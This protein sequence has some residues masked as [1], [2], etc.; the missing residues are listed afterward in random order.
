M[1]I[2]TRI[3]Q[4][5]EVC[6]E[7]Y[8]PEIKFIIFPFGEVGMQVKD[9]LNNAY[10]IEPAYVLDNNLCKYNKNINNISLISNLESKEYVLVLASTNGKIYEDLKEQVRRYNND[11]MIV[12]ILPEQESVKEK[13]VSANISLPIDVITSVGKY[14]YGPLCNHCLVESVG[15]FCS[16]SSRSDVVP[17][18]AIQL[19]STHPFLYYGNENNEIHNRRY[20]EY[21]NEKWYFDGVE[22]KGHADKLKRIKIGNDVWIGRNVI[23]T[24]GA[25]IGDGAI[26]G[27]GAVVTK[28]VPAYAIVGG[29]PARIIRY[30]YTSEEIEAL[31]RI[32]WWDWTDDEIREKYEDFYLPIEEFIKK[33]DTEKSDGM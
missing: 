10:A 11:I 8:G 33:Y 25:N 26:I 14:S 17:N 20:E 31:E 7:T 18:H 28:D 19:I 15:A 22:P 29:V 27:A 30:R 4:S 9:I 2:T 24:N 32:K 3:K 1:S 23:I 13:V 12:E 21:A 5:I 16:I 6:L